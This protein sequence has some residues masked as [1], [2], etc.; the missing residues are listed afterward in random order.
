MRDELARIN[1][2]DI[3]TK[4]LKLPSTLR[5]LNSVMFSG[6]DIPGALHYDYQENHFSNLSLSALE[7]TGAVAPPVIVKGLAQD[8]ARKAERLLSALA[9]VLPD[10]RLL[11]PIKGSIGKAALHENI[12]QEKRTM[13][14]YVY[15]DLSHAEYERFRSGPSFAERDRLVDSAERFRE[16]DRNI[17]ILLRARQRTASVRPFAQQ[18]IAEVVD[19]T[20]SLQDVE[21][22]LATVRSVVEDAIAREKKTQALQVIAGGEVLLGAAETL[23]VTHEPLAAFPAALSFGHAVHA[24]QEATHLKGQQTSLGR[25]FPLAWIAG[26]HKQE[27][28]KAVRKGRTK[29]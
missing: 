18:V 6:L 7:L 3:A 25:R 11:P 2:G 16:A 8:H 24:W 22:E 9:I 12:F 15:G 27:R 13:Y 4:D 10:F 21:T 1:I 28:E 26:V 5:W 17:E 19:G 23:A 20:R 14:R 29:R